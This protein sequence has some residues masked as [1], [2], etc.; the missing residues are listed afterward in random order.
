MNLKHYLVS[1]SSSSS[2]KPAPFRALF[3]SNGLSL[4]NVINFMI[5]LPVAATLWSQDRL[6]PSEYQNVKSCQS[7]REGNRQLLWLV[8]DKGV[9]TERVFVEILLADQPYLHNRDAQD[10]SRIV[11]QGNLG[12]L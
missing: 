4:E 8:K 2:G 1:F 10:I 6:E 5:F 7:L 9:A 11:R 12:H 3:N